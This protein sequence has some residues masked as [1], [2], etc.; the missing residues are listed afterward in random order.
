MG[1]ALQAQCCSSYW[2]THPAGGAKLKA[3]CYESGLDGSLM[4]WLFGRRAL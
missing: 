2:W 3:I 1:N 4:T